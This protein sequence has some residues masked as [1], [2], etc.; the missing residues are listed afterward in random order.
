M[1]HFVETP[2]TTILANLIARQ[3]LGEEQMRWII[4]EMVNGRCD[5][6]LAAAFLMGLRMKGETAAEIAVAADVLRKHMVRW[7]PGQDSVLDTCGTG[8]DSSGTFNISTATALVVA[9]CGVPVVKHG[10]RSASSRSGSADVL[11]ALGVVA[12]GSPEHARRCLE[13]AGIA[14]CFAPLFHPALKHVAALRR[15]LA[16][17]TIFNWLGPLANPAGAS[18]QLLGVG[19]VDMLDRMAIALS[20]L[21]TTRSLV[22]HSEDGLDEVSLGAT[23]LV[24]EVIG[25]EIRSW[26]W[27]P[28]AFGL[29]R[30]TI[31]DWRAV[32]AQDSARII[33][34]ILAGRDGP[35]TWV[36]QANAAAGLWLTG[37][38]ADLAQ[39]VKLAAA[40]VSSGKARLVLDN[41]RRLCNDDS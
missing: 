1:I 27:T 26:Q 11:T 24:R 18:H 12:Q 35:C 4:E 25:S 39:G 38:V 2:S 13:Q 7:Q 10:N 34:E 20:R 19:R 8:G 32:D 41:L 21:A 30:C 16:I 23:T 22:I 36:V 33:E 31:A 9:A 28:E 6:S 40:A 5:S 3:D 17:P 29:P 14:F 15:Q 37:R